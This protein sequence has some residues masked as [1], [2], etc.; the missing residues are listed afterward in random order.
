M[1]QE[2]RIYVLVIAAGLLAILLSTCLGAL[3][4]GVAGYWAAHRVGRQLTEDW[5]QQPAP[6]PSPLVPEFGGAL[7]TKVVEGSPAERAGIQPGDLILAVD[8]TPVDEQHTL[9][10]VIR[11]HR[12]KD[13]VEIVILRGGRER[14]LTVTL[15]EHAE[16]AKAAYLGVFYEMAPSLIQPP[17]TD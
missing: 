5:K 3:A 12:P 2:R 1:E 11:R 4:G 14:T 17:S 8:G 7:V 15:A 16:D 10:D 6:A 13:R 9:T